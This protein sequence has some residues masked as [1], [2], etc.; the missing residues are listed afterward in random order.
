MPYEEAPDERVARKMILEDPR[1][2]REG[3]VEPPPGVHLVSKRI[4]VH[5]GACVQCACVVCTR[6]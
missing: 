2:V 6:K 3:V 5:V 1:E 4:I